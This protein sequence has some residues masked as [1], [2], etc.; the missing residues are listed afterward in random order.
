MRRAGWI[1]LLLATTAVTAASAT[2]P[3]TTT[4]ATTLPAGDPLLIKQLG[5]IDARVAAIKDLAA[6]F[7]QQKFTALL[8]K[9]LVSSGR[10]RIKGTRMRWDTVEPN[11][12]VMLIDEHEIR[13]YYPEQL[14]EEVYG[15]SGQL[16]KLA[17]SPLP[18]LQL[19]REYFSFEPISSSAHTL[20][21]RLTPTDSALREHLRQ[22][23]VAV[24]VDTGCILS[25]ETTDIDGDRTVMEFTDVRFNTGL[26]DADIDLKIP[27]AASITHPLDQLPGAAA[28][29]S[30]G[31]SK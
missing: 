27:P 16:E 21:L 4:P 19:L 31:S 1:L 28:E 12:S 18:R 7:R 15:I 23:S 13:I 25:M 2:T 26:D 30:R 5:A 6:D 10:I 8:K 20:A 24:D 3:P 29:G 22:V 17:S 9:P 11:P 14:L